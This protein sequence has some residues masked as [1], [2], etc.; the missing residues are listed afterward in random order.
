MNTAIPVDAVAK[1]IGTKLEHVDLRNVL[2]NTPLQIAIFANPSAAAEAGVVA[3]EPFDFITAKEVGDEFGYKS[4]AYRVAR[5]LRPENGGGVGSIRTAI[6][7]IIPTAAVLAT[8]ALAINIA[9]VNPSIN[10]TDFIKASGRRLPFAV[11]KTDTVD[12]LAARIKE[13]LDASLKFNTVDSVVEA[14]V[15]QD[16]DIT[17]TAGWNGK[18]GNEINIEI[19]GTAGTGIIYTNPTMAGGAGTF[20]PSVALANFGDTWFNVVINAL[21]VDATTFDFFEDFNGSPEDNTGRWNALLMKPF[22]AAYGSVETDKDVV[23]AIPDARKLD[24][25]NFKCVAPGSPGFTFEAA[26][27]YIANIAVIASENPPLAYTGKKLLDMPAPALDSDQGDFGDYFLRDF[28]EK[29]GVSTAVLKG[30]IY[31]IED[32]NTHYHPDGISP[33]IAPYFR[34][35]HILGRSFNVIFKYHLLVET[36]LMNKILVED[37]TKTANPQAIDPK[38]WG[39]IVRGFIGELET[40]AITTKGDESKSSVKTGIGDANPEKMETSFTLIYSNNVR[41]ADTVISWGFNFGG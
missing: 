18:T 21:D 32:V 35:V 6:F 25:T 38:Q 5:M 33:A 36:T 11:L 22:V 37:S 10:A 19:E 7:P 1:V 4:P 39:S 23:T 14:A 17:L 34:V 12:T 8:D 13:T 41:Q 27:A 15:G 2:A 40:A 16:I 31:Y 30:G 9:L 3:N 26:A 24:L 20:D 28:I 29:K